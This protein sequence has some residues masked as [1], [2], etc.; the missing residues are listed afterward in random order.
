MWMYTA[1]SYLDTWYL[2]PEKTGNVV[3]YFQIAIVNS[4]LE[5]WNLDHT[6]V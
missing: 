5:V 6:P 2:L 1:M 3:L 4:I